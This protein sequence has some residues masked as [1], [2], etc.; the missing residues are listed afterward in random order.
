MH[1]AQNEK[2]NSIFKIAINLTITCLIAGVILAAAYYITH[3]IALEKEKE[4]AAKS[5]QALV[6]DATSFA[7]VDGEEK[8]TAASKDGKI[9]A[10][11]VLVEPRGTAARL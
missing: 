1:K 9:I 2:K 7:A 5:M 11:I 3:P 10:Y 4:M 6:P 8:M